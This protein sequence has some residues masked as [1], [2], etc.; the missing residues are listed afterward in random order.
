[1]QRD[2][3]FRSGMDAVDGFKRLARNG[4][5]RIVFFVND[6][7]AVCGTEAESDFFYDG[8]SAAEDRFYMQV[9][10][11]DFPVVSAY[12]AFMHTKPSQMPAS[13]GHSLGNANALKAQVL[14]DF[15]HTRLQ[16]ATLLSKNN[17]RERSNQR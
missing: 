17:T 4:D 8:G 7:P 16:S 10:G 11:T 2:P 13:G 14:F 1:M 3:G 6:A 9:L 12:D 5:F 15:L